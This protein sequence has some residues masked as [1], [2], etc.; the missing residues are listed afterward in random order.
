MLAYPP[1]ESDCFVSLLADK[2]LNVEASIETQQRA[3]LKRLLI[4]CRDVYMISLTV[5]KAYIIAP[6]MAVTLSQSKTDERNSLLLVAGFAVA[7]ARVMELVTTC[8]IAIII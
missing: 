8:I 1:E 5:S 7:S 2:V 6:A 3:A 4:V